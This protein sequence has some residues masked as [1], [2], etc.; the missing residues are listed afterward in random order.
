MQATLATL[1]LLS[2]IA[3]WL[4]GAAFWWVVAGVFQVSVVPFTLTV[5]LPTNKQLLNPTLD[6]RSAQAGQLLGCLGQVARSE[7][8]PQC[9]RALTIPLPFSLHEI[10]VTGEST[11]GE[12]HEGAIARWDSLPAPPDSLYQ[13][14]V[15]RDSHRSLGSTLF[16]MS[17]RPCLVENL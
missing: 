6:R 2:S 17:L 8:H 15:I 9:S 1:C 3:A 14:H 16:G 11:N 4:A 10:R 7:K 12:K 5:I 13:V